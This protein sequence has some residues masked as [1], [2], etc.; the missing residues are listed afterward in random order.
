MV[1]ACKIF[2]GIFTFILVFYILRAFKKKIIPL[3]RIGYEI[4]IASSYPTCNHGIII[5]LKTI[6]VQYTTCQ[7]I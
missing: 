6:I 2:L 1:S 7:N 5:I 4:I 3:A